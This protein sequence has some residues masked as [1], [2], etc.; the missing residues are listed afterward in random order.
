MF[1]SVLVT[2][3]RAAGASPLKLCTGPVAA[4]CRCSAI[5]CSFA[6]VS[7]TYAFKGYAYM[8]V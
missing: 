5:V 2:R 1:L 3:W 7:N 4:D 6:G 8:P